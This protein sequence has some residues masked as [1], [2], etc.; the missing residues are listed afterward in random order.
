VPGSSSGQT[1]EFT[2]VISDGVA[3]SA[4]ARIILERSADRTGDDGADGESQM[5]PPDAT[6][7]PLPTT[8]ETSRPEPALPPL[9][10]SYAVSVDGVWAAYIQAKDSLK[11]L[12]GTIREFGLSVK[13]IAQMQVDAITEQTLAAQD[14]KVAAIRKLYDHYTQTS[15]VAHGVAAAFLGDIKIFNDNRQQAIS[16]VQ[17]LPL[18]VAGIVPN[19]QQ[20]SRWR[21]VLADYR[22]G[23]GV[24]QASTEGVYQ[25]AVETHA[26]LELALQAG[27]LAAMGVGFASTG[28]R[29]L[30]GKGCEAFA[31]YTYQT[32]V[33]VGVGI[34]VGWAGGQ[35]SQFAPLFG[36][37]ADDLRIGADAIQLFF[38][39]KAARSARKAA[40]ANCFIAGTEVLTGS[41]THPN[42]FS[43][44]KIEDVRAGDLVWSKNQDN[45]DA[46]LE[47]KRVTQ[48]FAH[49]AYDLQ[50]VSIRDG[51]GHLEALRVTD[52]HPFYVDG[53]G[54]TG[55][56]ALRAGD[57]LVS[58]DG[59]ARVVSGNA[60][61]KPAAGAMV[62]NFTVADAHTYFVADGVGA[63]AFTWV[64]NT[65]PGGLSAESIDSVKAALI[66]NKND[67]AIG[68]YDTK[69]GKMWIEPSSK[70]APG[71]G[72]HV[73]LLAKTHPE[74]YAAEVI[75][76]ELRGFVLG[77]QGNK[78]VVINNSSFNGVTSKMQNKWLGQILNIVDAA[79]NE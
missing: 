27:G 2:Y 47:L 34:G 52:E 76:G 72:G 25:A 28:A 64:H 18:S 1:V 10:M 44:R 8:D 43:D 59:S 54:W 3:D 73:D 4:P 49:R 63:D 31:H 66:K 19:A 46:P 53:R 38:L 20:L 68:I 41:S 62:Y 61:Y 9:Q 40:K 75:P 17:N 42:L 26:A 51:S 79:F 22:A 74:A 7:F 39:I 60:D 50:T 56:A 55:A 36:L 71:G 6:P 24:L 67:V 29:M 70:L 37:D 15:Q 30:A 77:Q 14:P 12:L 45:P 32:I 48:T 21:G 16:A 5:P 65:C 23:A 58:P 69:T 13:Q 11:A 78:F 35:V 57:R 33:N